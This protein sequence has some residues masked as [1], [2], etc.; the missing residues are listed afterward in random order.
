MLRGFLCSSKS[1]TIFFSSWFWLFTFSVGF[2]AF[3]CFSIIFLDIIKH[4]SHH[5]FDTD[6]FGAIFWCFVL[7]FIS[8]HIPGSLPSFKVFYITKNIYCKCDIM[9]LAPFTSWFWYFVEKFMKLFYTII[10]LKSRAI[11]LTFHRSNHDLTFKL[12]F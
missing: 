12:C 8:L 3:N 10:F 1:F 5:F 11:P 6:N 2:Q 4:D 7:Q 9:F